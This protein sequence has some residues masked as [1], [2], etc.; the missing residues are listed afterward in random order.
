MF[1]MYGS[2]LGA[3]KEAAFK[4]AEIILDDEKASMKDN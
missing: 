2:D 4:L 1:G 3:R